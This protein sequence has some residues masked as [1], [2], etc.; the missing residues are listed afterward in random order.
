MSRAEGL[1]TAQDSGTDK[2][3]QRQYSLRLSLFTLVIACVLPAVAMS[4]YMVYSN[5]QLQKQKIYGDTFLLAQ[6]VSAELE[7]ELSAIESGLRVLATSES[8]L[9]GDLRRFHRVAQDALKSQIVYSYILTDKAGRQMLNTLR[10]FGEPLPTTGTPAQMQEVFRSGASVLS[11]MFIGPVTRTPVI[12]M[13]VP[14]YR[15][16][17][18]I[19][20]L[21]VGLAP[22]RLNTILIRQ[23]LGEGWLVA[24]LDKSGTIIGRSRDAERFIGQKAVPQILAG[25]LGQ[26]QGSLEAVTKDGVPVVTSFLRSPVWHWTVVIG[27]PKDILEAEL[28]RMLFWLSS[29]ALLLFMLGTWLAASLANRVVSS[30]RELN[31]AAL[32]LGSGKAVTLPDVQ[33]HE[34]EAV[35]RAIVQASYLMAEVHHRAYH[36]SLTSLAN[37]TLF[38][39]LVQHQIAAADREQGTLVILAIDLDNFKAVNDQEGHSTG[40]RLLKSV[41]ERII[42]TI[43]ASDAAARMGGDEFSV[44]LCNTDHDSAEETARRLLAALAEPHSGVA[45]IVSASIGIAVYPEGGD[46]LGA[47]LES[48]DQA[49]YQAKRAGKNAFSMFV[50]TTVTQFSCPASESA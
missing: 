20:S 35:G 33:L 36:D 27:A 11:D 19:Y 12:A 1:V 10:P 5:Y 16:E 18:V 40:D 14:V 30:V 44:L 25:M 6:Q 37:R 43:R 32:A 48:A 2:V 46:T 49:L 28:Y 7:R 34:A 9:S 50:P 15:G 4:A 47:L 39:E 21:N 3:K 17:D 29:A 23:N 45:N 13:G 8:L 31:D 26:P 22:E 38:Y 42:A 24:I 41:A